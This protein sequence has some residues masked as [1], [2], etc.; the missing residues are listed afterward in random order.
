MVIT[1]EELTL[2]ICGIGLAICLI[3][4]KVT[5][6]YLSDRKKRYI[7]PPRGKGVAQ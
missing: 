5:P 6:T 2:I 4:L 7:Q 1:L 3:G